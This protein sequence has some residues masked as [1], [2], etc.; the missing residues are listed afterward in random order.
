MLIIKNR[1]KQQVVS[2]YIIDFFKKS[3]KIFQIEIFFGNK[4]YICSVC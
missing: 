1:Q 3:K 2:S 4:V